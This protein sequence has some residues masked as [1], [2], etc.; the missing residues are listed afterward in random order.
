VVQ[1]AGPVADLTAHLLHRRHS[2]AKL[3]NI[4]ASRD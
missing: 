3:A 2:Q 1:S 4:K